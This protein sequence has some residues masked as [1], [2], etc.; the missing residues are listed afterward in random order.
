MNLGNTVDE[1]LQVAEAALKAARQMAAG[2]K[3]IEALKKAGQLRYD[4]DKRRMKSE[5]TLSSKRAT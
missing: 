2:P 1:D 4:A 3:R 5:S